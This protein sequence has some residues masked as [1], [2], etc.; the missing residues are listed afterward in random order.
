MLCWR[1]RTYQIESRCKPLGLVRER[2]Q[3]VERRSRGRGQQ[4]WALAAW[5]FR[6]SG[7]CVCGV[8]S[9]VFWVMLAEMLASVTG[10]TNVCHDVCTT[11]CNHPTW[12][13]AALVFAV[14]INTWRWCD[15]NIWILM[16]LRIQDELKDSN[17]GGCR[18]TA[19]PL[20]GMIWQN[21][22][23]PGN[24]A[25][26]YNVYFILYCCNSI[27]RHR[28]IEHRVLLAFGSE[29]VGLL[30]RFL[31]IS[32]VSAEDA[33]STWVCESVL[34]AGAWVPYHAY[35]VSRVHRWCPVASLFCRS[36]VYFHIF[37]SIYSFSFSRK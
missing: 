30:W 18:I 21:L 32:R 17:R 12:T 14:C 9:P 6:H 35:I 29:F 3:D 5:G 36:Y 26:R 11:V 33:V 27:Q 7:A 22:R 28:W 20:V 23:H 34:S 1:R 16:N 15:V 31:F 2:P 19:I 4:P 13:F 8:V 10:V 24:S 25:M 37:R